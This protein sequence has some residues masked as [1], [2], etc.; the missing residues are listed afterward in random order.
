MP[1]NELPWRRKG[2]SWSSL[3]FHDEPCSSTGTKRRGK[4]HGAGK[5]RRKKCRKAIVTRRLSSYR[6]KL[7]FSDWTDDA[8]TSYCTVHNSNMAS[9]C[10]VELKSSVVTRRP[11]AASL[12]FGYASTTSAQLSNRTLLLTRRP[13]SSIITRSKAAAVYCLAPVYC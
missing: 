12:L 6:V 9:S 8:K 13:S 3:S 4:T 1:W 11:R 5:P 7:I 10:G 2:R